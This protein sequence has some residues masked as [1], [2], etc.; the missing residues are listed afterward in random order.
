MMYANLIPIMRRTLT[1]NVIFFTMSFIL[2]GCKGSEILPSKQTDVQSPWQTFDEAKQAYDLV[3][4]NYTTQEEL[5][6]IGFDPYQTANVRIL[7]YLEIIQRFLPN[8]AIQIE[9]LDEGIQRCIKAREKCY[10]Y[11]AS[12]SREYERRVGNVALD[13]LNFEKQTRVTGWKFTALMVIIEDRVVYK[14]WGGTPKLDENENKRN[15]LGPL[16]AIQDIAT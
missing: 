9:Q 6:E 14:I 1:M 12:P 8:P 13:L 4:P 2:V 11:F 7:T 15:P 16:E 5:Q 10:A 3:I